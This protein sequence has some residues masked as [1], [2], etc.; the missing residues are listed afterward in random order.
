[1]RDDTL[2]AIAGE[3]IRARKKHPQNSQSLK[4]AE[5][6]LAEL[7]ETFTAYENGKSSATQIYAVAAT[8]AAMAIRC[9]EE[10]SG[11]SKYRGNTAAPELELTP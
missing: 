4:M 5:N 8:V 3:L 10:G 6:Y 11:G 1:M 7:R 9:M 2:K